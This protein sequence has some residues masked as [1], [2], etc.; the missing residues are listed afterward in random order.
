MTISEFSKQDIINT[1][2][3]K[4]ESVVVAYPAITHTRPVTAI[5]KR[6]ALKRFKIGPSYIMYVGTIQPR[7]NLITLIEAFESVRRSLSAGVVKKKNLSSTARPQT[8]RLQLVIAGKIGWLAND[9]LKRIAASPFKR[10]I[11]LIG[12]VT[13]QQKLALLSQAQASVL[14]GL[15]EGFGIP[16]LESLAVGT[17]P[18]VSHTSSLPEVVGKAGL[19]VN[20]TDVA[21]VAR[22]IKK[23]LAIKS[24]EKLQFRALARR[25]V[26]RFSWRA[27]AEIIL[28]TLQSIV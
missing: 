16:A 8:A 10:D 12:F 6:L 4:T 20:P 24:R 27:S 7:K 5:D 13:E 11:K 9:T 25:Q 1:Y 18:I 3:R 28:E 23:T 21:D 22:A 15:Y 19:L 17:I 14:I 2:N 26:A